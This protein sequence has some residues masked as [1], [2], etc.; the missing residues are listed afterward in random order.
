MTL[1]GV[2]PESRPLNFLKTKSSKRKAK[3]LEMK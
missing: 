2:E 3:M 1:D